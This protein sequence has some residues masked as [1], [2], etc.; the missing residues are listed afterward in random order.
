MT[1]EDF[2]FAQFSQAIKIFNKTLTL[3]KEINE[4][5]DVEYGKFSSLYSL[6]ADFSY[7]DKSFNERFSK[8]MNESQKLS[9]Q[10][11]SLKNEKIISSNHK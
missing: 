3:F 8:L 7:Q 4:C 6:V 5:V 9:I 10:Y 11:W 2:L 1:L